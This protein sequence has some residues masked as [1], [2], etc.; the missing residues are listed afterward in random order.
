MEETLIERVV[1]TN[2]QKL[3][4]KGLFDKYYFADELLR[5]YFILLQDVETHLKSLGT[6]LF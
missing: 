1:E 6:F 4:E 2:L 3:Y 5:E